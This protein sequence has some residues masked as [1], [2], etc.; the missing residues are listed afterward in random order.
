[1]NVELQRIWL[2]TGVTTLLVTHGIDEA[3]F[4]ADRVAIMQAGPGRIV[5]VLESPFPRPRLPSLF[6]APEFHH[7]CDHIAGV[8]HAV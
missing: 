4:L 5:E 3:V 7:L 8:L 1:M 6:A 2:E